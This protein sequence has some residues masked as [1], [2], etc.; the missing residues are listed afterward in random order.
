M[1]CHRDGNARDEHATKEAEATEAITD[2]APT[3]DQAPVD[4]AAK[5]GA[6]TVENTRV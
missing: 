1:N 3:I 4:L 2:R 5:L 6:V